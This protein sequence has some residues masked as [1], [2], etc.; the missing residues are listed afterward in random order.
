MPALGEGWCP[1]KLLVTWWQREASV[2]ADLGRLK[3]AEDTGG[4]AN[5]WW[6]QEVAFS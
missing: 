1:G 4:L 6:E 5:S 3:A 2:A